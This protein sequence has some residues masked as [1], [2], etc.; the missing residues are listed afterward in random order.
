MLFMVQMRGTLT[1]IYHKTSESVLGRT[2]KCTVRQMQLKA[3][4]ISKGRPRE[5]PLT[6][7]AIVFAH[8]SSFW[9]A[10]RST[11]KSLREGWA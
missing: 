9:E 3:V 11:C 6:N 8:W 5:P 10:E 1:M 4:K 2:P 7:D